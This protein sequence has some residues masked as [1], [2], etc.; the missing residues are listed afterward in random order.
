MFDRS[1]ALDYLTHALGED[2]V[3]NFAK[4]IISSFGPTRQIVK[5]LGEALGT[6]SSKGAE[7]LF[8]DF[9]A[10]NQTVKVLSSILPEDDF[11]RSDLAYEILKEYGPCHVNV[12][13]LAHPSYFPCTRKRHLQ[14]LSEFGRPALGY[15]RKTAD[16]HT[17]RE[18]I[19]E[20]AA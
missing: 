8:L 5:A 14:I 1:L 7:E 18:K 12:K 13:I 17:I 9:G 16:F 20:Y 2:T 11:F 6:A 15:L 4:N 3:R 19:S 10:T